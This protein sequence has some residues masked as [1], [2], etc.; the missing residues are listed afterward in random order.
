MD[1]GVQRARWVYPTNRCPRADAGAAAHWCSRWCR[2]P[3]AVRIRKEPPDREPLREAFVL[4]PLFTPIVGHRVAKRGGHVPE[5]VREP[6]AGTPRIR[7]LTPCQE[8][9][10]RRPLHQG[11]AGRAIP[12][13]PF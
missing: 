12:G 11:A 1:E 13:P 4:S 10:A 2:V 8:N 6:I 3:R 9:P 5:R 7:P